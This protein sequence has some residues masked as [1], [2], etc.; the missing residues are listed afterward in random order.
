MAVLV[1]HIPGH[2]WLIIKSQELHSWKSSCLGDSTGN[3]KS[4]VCFLGGSH[5]CCHTS[6]RG[7]R[8]T[9][10]GRFLDQS[11]PGMM[12]YSQYT[13]GVYRA[14]CCLLPALWVRCPLPAVLLFSSFSGSRGFYF[15]VFPSIN[16]LCVCVCVCVCV[17]LLLKS[18]LPNA[19]CAVWLFIPIWLYWWFI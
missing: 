13:Q 8:A 19:Q 7:R 1:H 4:I 11:L 16:W 5:T 17:S 9:S 6:R 18:S 3:K 2:F 15:N 10:S 12:L 14:K